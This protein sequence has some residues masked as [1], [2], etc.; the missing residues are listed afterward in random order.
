MTDTNEL[1]RMLAS[2]AAPVR[3]LASPVRRTLRWFAFATGVIAAVVAVAGV[4]TGLAGVLAAPAGALEF[5]ASIATGIAAAYAAFQVSVPGRSRRWIW[6]PLPFALGWLGGL[7][8]GCLEDAARLGGAAFAFEGATR[9]CALAITLVSLPLAT[10]MLLMVRHA[11]VV[12]PGP[13]AWLAMLAAAALASAGVGLIH[14]GE[15]AWMVL[16]WHF[17]AVAVLSLACLAC[18]RPL[19][20]WIGHA[21]GEIARD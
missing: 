6:L 10:G 21:R 2:R 18:S 14:E 12:A 9:E 16:V 15:S 3:A 13:S 11:G 20:A 19:F 5:G 7:G 4:R 1:I 17:G 8:L